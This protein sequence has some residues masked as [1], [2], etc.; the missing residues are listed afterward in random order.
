MAVTR[1]VKVPLSPGEKLA[2]T[3]FVFNEGSGNFA[4]STLVRKLNAGDHAGACNEL[5][6]WDKAEVEGEAVALAGLTKRRAAERLVCLG[7]AAAR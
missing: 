5:S 2:Y 6:R 1:I 4:S 7:D 3:D